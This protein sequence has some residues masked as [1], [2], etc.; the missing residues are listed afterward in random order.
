LFVVQNIISLANNFSFKA[1]CNGCGFLWGTLSALCRCEYRQTAVA[2][3]HQLKVGVS[4]LLSYCSLNPSTGWT[5]SLLSSFFPAQCSDHFLITPLPSEAVSRKP[6]S[7]R[8]P[9]IISLTFSRC[10]YFEPVCVQ[11]NEIETLCTSIWP[12]GYKYEPS[13][14]TEGKCNHLHY[15]L[16]V[17]IPVVSLLTHK[18]HHCVEGKHFSFLTDVR[19]FIYALPSH[20]RAQ[21]RQCQDL[22]SST[23]C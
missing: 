8:L 13:N 7:V 4:Y 10:T 17:N 3:T 11:V 14:F 6:S 18:L 20:L 15:N 16:N 23:F 1:V 5:A 19:F 22:F 12:S 2:A 21:T 9:L